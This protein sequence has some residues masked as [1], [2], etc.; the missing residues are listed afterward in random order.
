M[1]FALQG[2]QQVV[3]FRQDIEDAFRVINLILLLYLD[4]SRA[5]LQLLQDSL[6]LLLLPLGLLLHVSH[7]HI[8]DLMSQLGI[9]LQLLVHQLLLVSAP[10][11]DA[12]DLVLNF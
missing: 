10:L 1:V 8:G 9:G 5:I 6:E 2:L 3:R 12:L 11:P 4:L 7:V